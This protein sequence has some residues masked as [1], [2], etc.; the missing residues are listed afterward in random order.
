MDLATPQVAWV[1]V[2]SSEHANTPTQNVR[3]LPRPQASTLHQLETQGFCTAPLHR[4][5]TTALGGVCP[6]P[7]AWL[8]G[9]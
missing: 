2:R 1:L 7:A 8:S 6:P 5:T 4:M 9:V 3:V